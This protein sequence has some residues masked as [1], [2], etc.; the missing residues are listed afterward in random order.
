MSVYDM[1]TFVLLEKKTS[2]LDD[3]HVP[4]KNISEKEVEDKV[5][6]WFLMIIY[7]FIQYYKC[8]TSCMYDINI[9]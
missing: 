5:P 9:I 6:I 3:V 2:L 1:V 4:A 7:R 8:H